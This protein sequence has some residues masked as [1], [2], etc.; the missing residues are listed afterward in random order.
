MTVV[1][2]TTSD[3][4][5]VA[6]KAL[7]TI[8]TKTGTPTTDININS[9]VLAFSYDSSIAA[10]NYA[11]IQDFGKYYYLKTPTITT[12][13]RIIFTF[14]VDLLKSYYNSIKQCNATVIRS[15]SIGSNDVPDS[16]L[17]VNPNSVDVVSVMGSKSFNKY[18]VYSPGGGVTPQPVTQIVLITGRGKE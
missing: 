1:F 9:P 14:E 15:Q 7:T 13:G 17:P 5:I 18:S 16:R 12:D 11:Y 4:P 8:T 3:S 2:Y 6:D 10:A